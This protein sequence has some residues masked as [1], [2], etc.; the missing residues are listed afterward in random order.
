MGSE[1]NKYELER[2]VFTGYLACQEWCNEDTA[3]V[4]VV[5]TN[6]NCVKSASENV[7]QPL[8]GIH[9]LFFPL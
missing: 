1:T 6:G 7:N 8:L 9:L 5:V 4:A 3:C 2:K